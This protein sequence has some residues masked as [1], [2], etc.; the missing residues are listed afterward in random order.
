MFGWGKSLASEEYLKS[1]PRQPFNMLEHVDRL[2]QEV[3]PSEATVIP[4]GCSMGAALALGYVVNYSD[5]VAGAVIT[6]GGIGGFHAEN[7]PAE[8][9]LFSLY[10]NL[11]KDGDIQGAANLMV[12]IWGDGPL[13]DPGRMPEP[14]AEQILNGISTSVLERVRRLA[15]SHWMSSSLT[16]LPAASY[17]LYVC[18]R[19]RR[20]SLTV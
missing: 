13:Q 3:L 12:R 14:L 2:R 16:R 18:K 5:H 17:I 1:Q 6:A 10:D 19:G 20:A 15:D 11:I 8:D 4:V 7:T 9:K